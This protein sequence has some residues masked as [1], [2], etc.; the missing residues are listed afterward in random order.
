L[1]V[2]RAFYVRHIVEGQSEHPDFSNTA[3]NRDVERELKRITIAIGIRERG[4]CEDNS[5]RENDSWKTRRRK[6]ERED[7]T[8]RGDANAHPRRGVTYFIKRSR[9]MSETEKRE[10]STYTLVQRRGTDWPEHMLPFAI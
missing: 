6:E 3:R 10:T 7:G 9:Y 2:S 8:R 5:S 1:A 4:W